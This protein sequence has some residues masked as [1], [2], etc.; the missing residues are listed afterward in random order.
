M[1]QGESGQAGRDSDR[2][3]RVGSHLN[4][5]WRVERVLG[6]GLLGPILLC[7]HVSGRAQLSRCCKLA[8]RVMPNL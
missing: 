8:C 3:S 5:D 2:D 6:Y 4:S 7:S 1:T